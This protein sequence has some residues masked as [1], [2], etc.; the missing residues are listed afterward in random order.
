MSITRGSE[1]VVKP[2]QKSALSKKGL[3]DYVIN[4]ASGCLH[5]CTF[6][7][8]PSTPVIRARQAHLKQHGIEDP[9]MTWGKYLLVRKAIPELLERQ[10]AGKRTWTESAAGQGVVLLC[11]GTDPYQNREVAD[12]TR[13]AVKILLKYKKRVRILTRSPL[14]LKDLDVLIHPNVTVGMSLPFVVN[15]LSRQIEP[16]APLPTDRLKALLEGS[17]QGCRVYV[18]IA[19]TPPMMGLSDFA[20]HLEAILPVNPEVIFW[21]PINA[22][23]SNGKRMLAAG[24]NFAREVMSKEAW[25]S[26]FV[27]QWGEIELAAQQAGCLERLHVWPDR[28]LS[29]AVDDTIL[30]Y[31]WHRPTVENWQGVSRKQNGANIDRP[32]PQKNLQ[33]HLLSGLTPDQ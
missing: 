20:S 19:P 5:G 1:T 15:D 29:G 21:E 23:G 16:F 26:C 4:V 27:R 24:L 10:L 8:V 12:I 30:H 31:W 25:A 14:W 3:C 9:Q 6:C 28:E 22:R 7:Y 11:S 13:D 32:V 17:R 18:A 33:M 2:L